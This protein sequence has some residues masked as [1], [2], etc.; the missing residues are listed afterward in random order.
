MKSPHIAF[1]LELDLGLTWL[2]LA[3]LGFLK[4]VSMNH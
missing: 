4:K 2:D 3:G 1:G